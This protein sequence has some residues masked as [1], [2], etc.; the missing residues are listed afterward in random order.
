MDR[1]STSFNDSLYYLLGYYSEELQSAEMSW[2]EFEGII[3]KVRDENEF[4]VRVI[5]LDF[6]RFEKML[7]KDIEENGVRY[8]LYDLE[9]EK[10]WY[11]YPES[12]EEVEEAFFCIVSK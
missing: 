9:A 12:P 11:A 2:N 4:D 3:D 10:M 6:N 5:K 1:K 7:E 8:L